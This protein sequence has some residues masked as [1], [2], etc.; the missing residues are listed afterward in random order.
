[1]GGHGMM[2]HHF[3]D[4]VQ[5]RAK[6]IITPEQGLNIMKILSAM[7]ESAEKGREVRV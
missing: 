7:Y 5:K 3:V 4:V 1:M 2:L 6:P